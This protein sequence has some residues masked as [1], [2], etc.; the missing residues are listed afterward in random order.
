M[1]PTYN[2]GRWT[3]G[4]FRGFIRATLRNATRR[5]PPKYDTINAAKTTKKKNK[6]TSRI[7]Q[8]FRCAACKK[9]YVATEI[10]VD[11]IKPV[12]LTNFISWDDFITNLFC[13][14]DNL[15]VLCKPCHKKKTKKERE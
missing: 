12:V 5:W 7:A 1:E 14:S 4:R 6:K 2:N 9:E 15:Q 13:D 3:A 11:H 8:H 10:Q